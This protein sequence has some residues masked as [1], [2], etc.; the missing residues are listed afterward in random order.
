MERILNMG[1]LKF[2]FKSLW[3][4]FL[5]WLINIPALY[6]ASKDVTSVLFWFMRNVS[7][8][9]QAN[10][11]PWSRVEPLPWPR[12]GSDSRSQPIYC[13]IK[14]GRNFGQSRLNIEIISVERDFMFNSKWNITKHVIEFRLSFTIKL[15]I[16]T[17]CDPHPTRLVYLDGRW[18]LHQAQGCCFRLY[19]L[20]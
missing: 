13:T 15:T 18:C 9:K 4:W 2:Y 1:T 5:F 8:C 17:E 16:V 20:V 14:P 6:P 19:Y 3:C 12:W 10:K 7:I 11:L